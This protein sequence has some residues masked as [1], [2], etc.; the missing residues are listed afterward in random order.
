VLAIVVSRVV[1][2]FSLGGSGPSRN[3][4]FASYQSLVTAEQMFHQF[5]AA[6]FVAE[7]Y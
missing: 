6:R 1:G 2:T 3:C 4:L 5:G 7:F